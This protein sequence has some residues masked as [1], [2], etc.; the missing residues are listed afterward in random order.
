MATIRLIPS[1]YSVSNTTYLSVSNATNMY[2]NTDN[3]TYA[4]I[5]NSRASTTSYYLYINGFNFSDIPT[6]ATINSFTVKIKC[7]ESGITTSTSYR[8]YL[9][10]GTTVT[11]D[12]ASTMPSTSA[13]TITFDN[14]SSS[15]DTISGYGSN[16]G[17]RINCRRNSSSTTGTLY[18]YG[19]EILVDYDVPVTITTTITNGTMLSENPATVAT[20]SS[21]TIYFK[22]DDANYD[23]LS[24]TA[25]GTAVEPVGDTYTAYTVATTSNATYTVSTNYSTYSGSISDTIDGDTSTYWWSNGSQT[26]GNY[27]LITFSDLIRLNSF[28]TYSSKTSDY[29]QSNNVLQ[30]S[31]DGENWE[32]I[33]TFQDSQTST[34]SNLTNTYGKYIR[35]YATSTIDYWLAIAEITIDYNDATSTTM[36]CYSYTI[37]SVDADTTI[38]ITCGL[39][40]AALYLKTGESTWR[41]VAKIY[42]KVTN[43]EKS[44]AVWEEVTPEDFNAFAANK[45]FMQLEIPSLPVGS[46]SNST[47]AI[48]IT[49]DTLAADT[50]TLYYED[51][52]NNKLDG[53]SAIGTITKS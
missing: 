34:F 50:Y 35:I 20:G 45:K 18:V 2:N 12:Y 32:N 38:V 1:A 36:N 46:I 23:I 7:Y 30:I 43:K 44:S 41:R 21:H 15:W 24:M 27:V 19:A 29:P 52:N 25:N 28:S 11:S 51:E 26:S 3:T 14:V 4:T 33:G 39:P 22:T 16:F 6:N 53:W 5:T 13:Q 9:C 37:P 17:I 47:N 10:N 8:M 42:K 40:D 31:T 49:E 48:N